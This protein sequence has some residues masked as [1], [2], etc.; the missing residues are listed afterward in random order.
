MGANLPLFG[1]GET[2][3]LDEG[4]TVTTSTGRTTVV[5]R[6][7]DFGTVSSGGLY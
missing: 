4:E 7:A 3:P 5:P 1:R 2:D 6:K